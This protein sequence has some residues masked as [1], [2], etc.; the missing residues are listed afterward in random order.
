MNLFYSILILLIPLFASAKPNFDENIQKPYGDRRFAGD[1]VSYYCHFNIPFYMSYLGDEVKASSC[2]YSGFASQIGQFQY[3]RKINDTM[4]WGW[5]WGLPL[6]TLYLEKEWS[7]VDTKEFTTSLMLGGWPVS[8]NTK[9]FVP[10]IQ[11][12]RCLQGGS[13]NYFFYSGGYSIDQLYLLS[14]FYPRSHIYSLNYESLVKLNSKGTLNLIF[15]LGVNYLY[16]SYIH[17]GIIENDPW[18]TTWAEYKNFTNT[19][20][21]WEKRTAWN[22]SIGINF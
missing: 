9:V 21:Q 13:V 16:M 3:T 2:F 14:P 1:Y 17:M 11:R 19:D 15:S 6:L 7:I 10:F 8:V 20:T 22:A 5:G 4:K 12:K 18:A